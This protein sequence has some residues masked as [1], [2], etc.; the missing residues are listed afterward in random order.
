MAGRIDRSVSS[1]VGVM[2]ARSTDKERA[3]REAEALAL[4]SSGAGSAYA[5]QVLAERHG[6]SLRQGRRYVAAASFE[7]CDAATPAELDR[8]AMLSLHRLDL[9]AGRAMQAED[10]ALAVSATK[11]HCAALSQ[12]RRAI[13]V[14]G[15]RFRLPSQAGAE[16]PF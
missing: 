16:L 7:L 9:V 8:Q 4:L 5:A 11:A 6:V 2:A 3:S 13:S 10:H 14:P 15:I 1:G 12:F